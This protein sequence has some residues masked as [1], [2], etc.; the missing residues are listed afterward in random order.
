MSNEHRK[1]NAFPRDVIRA[2][3]IEKVKGLEDRV[4]HQAAVEE[5]RGNPEGSTPAI[6]SIEGGDRSND[7][8]PDK[9]ANNVDVQTG[10]DRVEYVYTS[11]I[12][13]LAEGFDRVIR[14]EWNAAGEMFYVSE[15]ER[16]VAEI[17]RRLHL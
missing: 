2:L 8:D 17:V 12:P 16:K 10:K 13:E 5:K 14:P 7:S 4:T 11:W 15:M 9:A 6:Q 3:V 1:G